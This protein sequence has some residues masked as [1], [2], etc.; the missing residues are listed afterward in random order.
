[1]YDWGVSSLDPRLART[2]EAR[3]ERVEDLVQRVLDGAVRIPTF[4][5][6]LRW[7]E[8]DVLDFFDSINRGLP[9]GSLLLS[10]RD[11]EA[12][13]VKLGPIEIDAPGYQRAWWVVD[14]QQ[15]LTSLAAALAR[16]LPFAE[17]DDEFVVYF[18]PQAKSF[19][20][21]PKGEIPTH[22]VE[23]PR[24]RESG[25]LN[26]WLLEWPHRDD[27]QLNREVILAG[28]RIRDYR[29]PLYVVETS[30][31]DVLREIFFRVNKSGKP[32]D[33]SEVHDA[34]Y[35][36]RGDEP[37]TLTDLADALSE[38][39]MGRREEDELV[40]DM[41]AAL[42]LDPTR[43]L[44][45][46]RDRGD[47]P[48]DAAAR[49]LPALKQALLFLKKRAEIPHLRLLPRSFVVGVVARFFALHPSPGARSK[50]LLV[51]WVWRALL[52]DGG[53]DVRTL[54]R[55]A[56]ASIQGDEEESVQA[57]L[58]TAPKKRTTVALDETFDGRAAQS[59]LAALAMVSLKPRSLES[60]RPLDVAHLLEEE[61]VEAFKNVVAMT[62]GGPENR[63]LHPR[64]DNLRAL[65]HERAQVGSTDPVLAS[66]AIGR[67]A[68]RALV[69]KD[70]DRLRTS[71]RAEL[72]AALQALG[73]RLA[74]WRRNDN[75]RPSIEHI[76]RE[77]R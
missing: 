16:P 38:L 40:V 74:G 30:E 6:G 7:A 59:K 36:N 28:T 50:T 22:W 4:Q 5:R 76:V 15:R 61:G 29:I 67:E 71:R 37:T 19:L 32:L 54:S 48:D 26:A 46:H 58:A 17:A 75:D 10:T 64:A 60:G 34:L 73:D 70:V 18:D 20:G 45:E 25:E 44:K 8:K 14:G 2:P 12:G 72:T 21:K 68:A 77:R 24:L 53:V 9:V 43:N 47:W 63:M 13:V 52:L 65:I 55:R 69:E 11:A 49:T 35:G 1:V 3:V 33:W 62:K 41:A 66:H 31:D 27:K 42:G 51:R 23:L 56:V 39:A 57:L